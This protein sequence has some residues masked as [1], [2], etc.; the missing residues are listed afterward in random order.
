L[1]SASPYFDADEQER[2]YFVGHEIK[3]ELSVDEMTE[4]LT[5]KDGIKGKIE[6]FSRNS[7]S[8]AMIWNQNLLL[9]RMFGSHFTFAIQAQCISGQQRTK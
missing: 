4:L 3:G 9:F 5:K 6:V 1:T 8:S 7:M 2:T